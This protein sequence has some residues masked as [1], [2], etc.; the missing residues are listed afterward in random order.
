M[1]SFNFVLV[2]CTSAVTVQLK[3]EVA[4]S[5]VD[6]IEAKDKAKKKKESEKEWEAKRDERVDGWRDF[7]TKST[8]GEGDEKAKAKK[9]LG[10]RL[11]SLKYSIFEV[12]FRLIGVR[13][14]IR[15]CSL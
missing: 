5:E 11:C 7:M 15:V 3:D 2:N 6:L 14:F 13:I 8:K 12:E 1:C 9:T 4:K 10:V